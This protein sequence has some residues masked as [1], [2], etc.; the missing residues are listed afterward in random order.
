M[1]EQKKMGVFYYKRLAA[2]S[3]LTTFAM[4]C[5]LSEGTASHKLKASM[6]FPRIS[7]P[8]LEV[9]YLNGSRMALGVLHSQ[10]QLLVANCCTRT[11]S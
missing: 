3:M 8:G 11:C 1:H 5:S 2:W 9:M 7:L 6:S 4:T 10:H